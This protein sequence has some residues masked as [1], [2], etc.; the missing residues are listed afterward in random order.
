MLADR[1]E[2]IK[3]RPE[4]NEQK[5]HREVVSLSKVSHQH[6]VRYF[7]CWMED[8]VRQEPPTITETPQSETPTQDVLPAPEED[9]F[10]VNWDDPSLYKREPSRSMSFPRIRFHKQADGS[11][12]SSDSDTDSETDSDGSSDDQDTPDPSQPAEAPRG[13]P[14]AVPPKPSM[15]ITG[16]TVDDSAVQ[17]ILYIQME[18]VEKVGALHCILLVADISKLCV[19]LSQLV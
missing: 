7:G 3:L 8:V 1:S 6:I 2:K 5:V 12:S 16:T 13:R 11:D 18:F 17:R 14:I 15:S 19:K 9:I 10:K 4:D